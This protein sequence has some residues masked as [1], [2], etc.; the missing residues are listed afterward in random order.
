MQL[1]EIKKLY[2][3]HSMLLCDDATDIYIFDNTLCIAMYYFDDE[4][5]E[6]KQGVGGI[7]ES[8]DNIALAYINGG[9]EVR[10]SYTYESAKR[11]VRKW[12]RGVYSLDDAQHKLYEIADKGYITFEEAYVSICEICTMIKEKNN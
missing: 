8:R 3:N 4:D 6:Y 1:N 7:G 9:G 11:I 2:P 5:G 10:Y 12:Q